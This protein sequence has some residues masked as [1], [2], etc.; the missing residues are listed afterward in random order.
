LSPEI[1][2]REGSRKLAIHRIVGWY[3]VYSYDRESYG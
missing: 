3:T 2:P 1:G